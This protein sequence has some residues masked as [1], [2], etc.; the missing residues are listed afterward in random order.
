PHRVQPASAPPSVVMT[1][2]APPVAVPPVTA[3]PVV[4]PPVAAP[5]PPA[6]PRTV[7]RKAAVAIAARVP[8]PVHVSP[9]RSSSR[10]LL[11]PSMPEALTQDMIATS[12]ADA[13]PALHA[14]AQGLDPH[15]VVGIYVAIAPSGEVASITTETARPALRRCVT[16]AIREIPFAATSAGGF[17]HRDLAL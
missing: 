1:A 17:F 12:L 14:C 7:P 2:L 5:V 6:R 9:V 10:A 8:A 4:P 13:Q 15:V 11:D 16:A 3:P